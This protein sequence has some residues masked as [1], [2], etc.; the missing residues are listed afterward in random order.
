MGAGVVALRD[1]GAHFITS[2]QKVPEV[3]AWLESRQQAA[4]ASAQR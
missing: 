3:A 4:Q 1:A 2:F